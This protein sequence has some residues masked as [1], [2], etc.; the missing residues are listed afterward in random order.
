[1]CEMYLYAS[2]RSGHTLRLLFTSRS[3]MPIPP[4]VKAVLRKDLLLGGGAGA[5]LCALI[6]GA[7]LSVGSL[8]GFDW[9]SD[10]PAATAG[11]ALRL[12]AIPDIPPPGARR[13]RISGPR[14]VSQRTQPVTGGTRRAATPAVAVTPSVRG[15]QPQL[16]T[17]PA[18]TRPAATRPPATPNDNPTVPG[19]PAPTPAPTAPAAAPVAA[20]PAAAIP[21]TPVPVPAAR[22]MRLS[23]ASV[24]VTA[25]ADGAP[26]FALGLSLARGPARAPA[27]DQVTVRLR[28]QL[29]GR[30]G[31]AAANAPLALQANLDVIDAIDGGNVPGDGSAALAMRVRM[32]IA[33]TSGASTGTTPTVADAGA[34]D[35]QSNVIA[36]SV[37]LAAFADPRH[38]SGP[39]AGGGGGDDTPAPPPPPGGGGGDDAP[40]PPPAPG[41]PAAP[42]EV[43]LNIAPAPDPGA[44]PQADTAA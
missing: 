3:R 7:A 41:P 29:P 39:P 12:P 5:L 32:T 36:V 6:A 23:V 28:P 35:G 20:T 34:G 14:V 16:T 19:A 2:H 42:T 13:P 22:G 38:E 31:A 10:Q 9:G 33:S 4:P 15:Q 44:Q 17:T 8:F 24:A 25:A 1:M 37:P 18:A 11:P 30:A 43:V 27:P 26:E 40:P 21:A